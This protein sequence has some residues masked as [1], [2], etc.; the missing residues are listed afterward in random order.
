MLYAVGRAGTDAELRE[1][2]RLILAIL[3]ARWS[4]TNP[5]LEGVR[6]NLFDVATTEKFYQ[7]G[8]AK[9]VGAHGDDRLWFCSYV[10]FEK[11][12]SLWARSRG[13][14]GVVCARLFNQ[15]VKNKELDA[16]TIQIYF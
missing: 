2:L 8:F 1:N 12:T 4:D 3:L 10:G 13:L 9:T 14:H 16:H 11:A 6:G 5:D 15:D 7:E